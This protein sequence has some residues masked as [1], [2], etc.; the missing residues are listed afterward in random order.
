MRKVFVFISIVAIAT[1]FSSCAT[2]VAGGD[3]SITIS[4]SSVT[5]PVTITTDKLELG[6]EIEITQGPLKG[7]KGF[8]A[9]KDKSSYIVLK[10]EMGTSHYIFTEINIQDIQPL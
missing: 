8:L 10:M 4:S 9:Q 2:I 3:P 6:Q 1:L 5:E 7:I